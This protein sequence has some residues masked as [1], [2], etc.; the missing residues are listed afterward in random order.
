MIIDMLEDSY[1][2]VV[3]KLPQAAR[4]ALGWR[5]EGFGQRDITRA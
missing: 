4:E 5:A 1:D 3:S 2:M